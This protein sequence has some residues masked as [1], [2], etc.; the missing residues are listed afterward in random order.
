MYRGGILEE[1][2]N[3]FKMQNN[4]LF[5]I[6]LINVAVFV[7]LNMLGV[8]LWLFGISE[9]QPNQCSVDS[10]N[11]FCQILLFFELPSQTMQFITRPWTLI[12]YFFTHLSFF[13]ILFN[14]LFLYWFGKLIQE[15]LGD[16][17]V[18]VLYVL[19]G[20]VGG[21]SYIL[22]Y[23][24]LPQFEGVVEYAHM[25]G[26]SAGVYAV[27]VGAAAFMPNYTIYLIL[28]G[29][30][31]IKYIAIIWVLLSF[32]AVRES[33]AGGNIAHLGGAAIGYLYIVQLKK[34]NDFG[35]WILKFI[36]YVKSFFV[37]RSK[38][39]VTY[40]SAKRKS[41]S[42]SKPGKKQAT[43]DQAEIDSILDKISQS[44]YESLS[45]DEKQKLFNASK[46]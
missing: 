42:T 27:V 5:Q 44:G 15:F 14:M 7:A 6:I 40:S 20:I 39:K 25:M 13:H 11:L 46:K 8:L 33:N 34:G 24:I 19:G 2:K 22:L 12:T 17:K 28:I 30:V 37:R 21:L 43:P 1:F 35:D 36:A 16:S 45:K 31:R 4:G 9:F 32:F 29:P 10:P 38:I 41:S 23:T 26:A 3:A 18:V